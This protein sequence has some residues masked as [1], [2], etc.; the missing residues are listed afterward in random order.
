[1]L[2]NNH[3]KL[4]TGLNLLVPQLILSLPF[5]LA[6]VI[7]LIAFVIT[8]RRRKTWPLHRL[9]LWI[10]GISCTIITVA[11]PLA[12]RSH[13]DFTAHMLGHLLL[14]MLA[15]LLM[16]LAR[17]MTLLLRTMEV[18]QAR[19]LISILKS[20]PLRLLCHPIIVSLLNV[21]GL[22]ILY[23]TSLF[24]TMHHNGWLHILVHLHVFLAGYFFT[25][26]F[27]YADPQPHRTGFLYRSIVLILAL[28]CHSILSKYI[29][30][31]PPLGVPINQAK[32]GGLLMYY[33]GDVIELMLITILCYQW[34]KDSRPRTFADYHKMGN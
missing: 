13:Q 16:V 5:I 19:M 30:A 31:H 8:K 23:L 32:T 14:G 1:M 27:I 6:L 7:Y 21:G 34:Y 28:A 26:A 15:P 25:G 2:L 11:G 29:Y 24:Q 3:I 18:K 33:G 22:W 9:F 17:P 4:D 12:A 10:A 20:K